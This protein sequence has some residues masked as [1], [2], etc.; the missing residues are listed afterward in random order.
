MAKECRASNQRVPATATKIQCPQCGQPV[1]LD[2]SRRIKK[3]LA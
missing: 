1:T 2:R 3:H